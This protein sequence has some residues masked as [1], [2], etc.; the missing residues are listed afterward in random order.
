V[1]GGGS[2]AEAHGGRRE[3]GGEHC[4]SG[5]AVSKLKLGGGGLHEHSK[6]DGGVFRERSAAIFPHVVAFKT[7]LVATPT[8]S[9]VDGN[10]S[11]CAGSNVAT[12]SVLVTLMLPF[13]FAFLLWM[14]LWVLHNAS[15]P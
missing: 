13:K 1:R 3:D 4:R 9:Q 5:E 11:R 6:D 12:I 14:T 2:E 15:A 8:L 10:G 7:T